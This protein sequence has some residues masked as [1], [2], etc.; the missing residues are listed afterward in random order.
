MTSRVDRESVLLAVGDVAPDR[1]DPN[2]CFDLIRD[3][4]RAAELV[5]CQLE[6]VL[7]E[8]GARLPQARHAVRGRPSIA[9]ALRNAN[10][11]V[12]SVA[13]NH[14]MDWGAEALLETIE[15]LRAQE[16]DVVGA[17]ENIRAARLPVIRQVGNTRVAFLAYC[18]ILPMAYWAEE[19]RAGCAP[20]RA[21]TQY[22]QIEHDQPGT[23]CRIHTYADHEDLEAMRRDIHAARSMVDV[24]IVSMHWGIHFIP[25]VIADYQREAGHAAIDAGADVVLGHHAHILKGIEMYRERP[26]FY[27]L[28]NF[29]ID[30]RMDKAHAESKSF[31]EIQTLNSS[32]TPDFDSLYNFPEDSKLAIVARI[33]LKTD[34]VQRVSILPA[35]INRQAQPRLVT[36]DEPEFN[37]VLAYMRD[38]SREAGLNVSF[39]PQGN[40]CV[41]ESPIAPTIRRGEAAP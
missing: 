25:T 26:I 28:G 27:S 38:A 1:P 9:A 17:G 34:G 29:A 10:F 32:W 18:S 35:Y 8:K 33:A 13:G 14:C 39:V 21:W 6:A 22:E 41:I 30:L 2:E 31:R 16:L 19:N 12:I 11:G 4:L 5:F 3:E 15:R 40:E 20:M 37:Q 36:P 24:V 7:T 23:P